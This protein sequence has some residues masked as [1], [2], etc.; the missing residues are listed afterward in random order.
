[1][2]IQINH[3][4]KLAYKGKNQVELQVV[5]EK[6][7]YKSDEWL[8]FLQAKNS[9]LMIKKGSKGVSVFKGFGI[10]EEVTKDGKTKS[11]S[12]PLGSAYVFNLD[13]TEKLT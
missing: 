8:T 1:M 3:I 11:T 9:G 4:T 10:K 13:C 7:G 5:K 6:N 12:L 2:T